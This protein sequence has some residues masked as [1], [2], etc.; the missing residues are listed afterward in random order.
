MKNLFSAKRAPD[1]FLLVLVAL[2]TLSGLVILA[3]ASSDLAKTKF[4]DAY[5]YIKHQIYFGLSLGVVGFTAACMLNY[6]LYKKIA[7]WLLIVSI[8]LL[9]LVFTHFGLTARNTNRWVAFGPISFQPAEIVKLTFVI[10]CAAWLAG[11]QRTRATDVKSGLIPFAI[12]SGIIG[13]L[14]IL[15][16]ATSTVVILMTSILAMYFVSGAPIKYIAYLIGTGLVLLA[17]II[18]ITPYRLQ[19]VMT[20]INQSADTQGSGYHINQALNAIGTG[21]MWGVGYGQSTSKLSYLP[22]PTDDSI[23]AV[24]A[25]E[26]GFVGASVLVILFGLLVLRLLY[27]AYHTRDTFGSLLLIG[28]AC[29]IGIQAFVNMASISGIAPL[30]GVPLP[31]ISYG[32]TALAIFLT[33]MGVCVNVSRNG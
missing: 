24:V 32:G 1:Y 2:L 9:A 19:R 7:F 27:G 20:Y 13:G 23:F 26:M 6:H 16:P 18:Y 21:K 30:T 11:K 15:Q 22:T 17:I 8:I 5:Y 33:M 12:V 29:I 31:F 25:E 10:Y 14:L 4:N 3:S 28:F